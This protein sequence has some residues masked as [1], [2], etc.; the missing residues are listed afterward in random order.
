MDNISNAAGV[1]LGWRIVVYERNYLIL[2]IS[3]GAHV[4]LTVAESLL[5]SNGKFVPIIRI[6]MLA[7]RAGWRKHKL[8]SKLQEDIK[9]Y[10]RAMPSDSQMKT[11]VQKCREYGA[12]DSMM[13]DYTNPKC[14]YSVIQDT[15]G[16]CP[17][18]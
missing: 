12:D 15:D 4:N 7:N 14:Y 16:N 10:K 18:S 2:E 3:R 5:D 1:N 17:D 9:Y 8:S 13:M 6:I 11:W